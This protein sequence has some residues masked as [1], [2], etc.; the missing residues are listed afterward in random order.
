MMVSI[1]C[2]CLGKTSFDDIFVVNIA[3]DND[4]CGSLININN[5]RISDLKFLIWNKKKA[6]LGINDSDI[7]DLWKVSIAYND[8]NKLKHV[9]TEDDIK[10]E[11][12]GKKLVPILLVKK[13][14]LEQSLVDENIHVIVQLP[15]AAGKCLPMFYLSNK[16]FAVT[17]INRHFTGIS[18]GTASFFRVKAGSGVFI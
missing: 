13:L 3:N 14:I 11:L 12:G 10:K 8:E 18:Q 9:T 16:K 17:N 7:M 6:T 5:L 2:L 4:I 1:N 15:T